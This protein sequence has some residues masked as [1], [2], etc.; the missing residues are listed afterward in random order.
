[1]LCL[2][3]NI[4]S[5]LLLA[6]LVFILPSVNAESLSPV[7][8]VVKAEKEAI[9][10]VEFAAKVIKTPDGVGASFSE[11]DTLFVFDCDALS[12]DQKAAKASHMAAKRKYQ[13]NLELQE[14]GAVGAIDVGISEAEM[15]EAKARVSSIKARSKNCTIKAPFD[16]RVAEL[17]INPFE[18]SSANA[19]LMKI[20]GTEALELRLIVPSIWLSWLKAGNLFEFQ[21]DET[22]TS[23]QA[24]VVRVGAEVDAV[25]R[26]IP[27]SAK[28]VQVPP[29]VL[30][31]MS[32]TAYFPGA[33]G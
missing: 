14:H 6:G 32:G 9:I 27:I 30:P 10:S 20:V 3:E 2:K 15:H 11:N 5:K 13:N 25:S 21:V 23:F 19:P 29:T 1:M 24:E 4:K 7:R 18:T 8:G 26:T 22:G 31:G 16:G 17:G 12:A 28:F 33:G